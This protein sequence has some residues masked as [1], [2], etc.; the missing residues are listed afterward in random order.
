MIQVL[1]LKYTHVTEKIVIQFHF[2]IIKNNCTVSIYSN[3]V[4]CVGCYFQ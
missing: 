2:H 3:T 1:N 4:Y